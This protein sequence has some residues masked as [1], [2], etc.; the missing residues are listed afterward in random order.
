[1]HLTEGLTGC[2]KYLAIR[3]ML[4]HAASSLPHGSFAHDLCRKHPP[5]IKI[6]LH[7]QRT[8]KHNIQVFKQNVATRMMYESF[9]NKCYKLFFVVALMAYPSASTRSLRIYQCDPI[10][11]K[12]YLARD[13]SIEC[14]DTEWNAWSAWSAMCIVLYVVGIPVC[15]FVL[16]HRAINRNLKTRWMD[17]QRNPKKLQ[18]LLKEAEIDAGK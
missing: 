11:D 7:I 16:L 8:V 18:I 3:Q 5:S 2:A 14:F 9:Q 13:L 1:M 17:C 12:F 10:G 6:K 15:F 4:Q